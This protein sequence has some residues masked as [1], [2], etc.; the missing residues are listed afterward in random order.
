MSATMSCSSHQYSFT[1]DKDLQHLL[2]IEDLEKKHAQTI[3]ALKQQHSQAI[4]ALKE[5]HEKDIVSSE[6]TQAEERSSILDVCVAHM[7]ATDYLNAQLIA[8][9]TGDKLAHGATVIELHIIL[10]GIV[11]A[12]KD[13][14]DK[15]VSENTRLKAEIAEKDEKIY[16]LEFNEAVN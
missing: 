15:L 12:A 1:D 9:I 14:H 16:V 2:D 13:D 11:K 8:R 7:G 5:Q 6:K 10:N 4:A 3:A